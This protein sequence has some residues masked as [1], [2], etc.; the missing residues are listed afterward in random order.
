MKKLTVIPM[1]LFSILVLSAPVFAATTV[2]V[3]DNKVTIDRNQPNTTMVVQQAAPQMVVVQQ[4]PVIVAEMQ[5]PR[6]LEGEII[7]V[8]MPKSLIVVRDINSRER[9]VL[10]KQGMISGYKVDDYV[11]IYLMADLKEAKTIKTIQTA[12]LDG[13]VVSAD[14]SRNLLVVR[15]GSGMDRVVILSPGMNNKYQAKD[16]VRLY[17]IADQPDA[18]EVRL[19]R[20]K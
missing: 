18:K 8:D 20:V 5:D 7:R 9:K 14:Y 17:V 2:T 19:I 1:M 6:K 16:H 4:V 12:D 10:L 11:Q 13:E 3:D 15:D